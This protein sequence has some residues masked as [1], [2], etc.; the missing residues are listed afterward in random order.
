MLPPIDLQHQH[1]PEADA[2]HF[3]SIPP[4]FLMAYSK[5][6][7]KHNGDIASPRFRPL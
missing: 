3:I 5:S 6:K 2:S 7:L 1:K 4:G